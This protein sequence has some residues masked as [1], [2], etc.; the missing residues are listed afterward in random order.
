[1]SVNTWRS[2]PNIC[3]LVCAKLSWAKYMKAVYGYYTIQTTNKRPRKKGVG[4]WLSEKPKIWPHTTTILTSINKAH[5]KWNR[6]YI[7]QVL[8]TL[9][10]YCGTHNYIVCAEN[11]KSW[12]KS[13]VFPF[14][15]QAYIP[16][17]TLNCMYDSLLEFHIWILEQFCPDT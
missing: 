7:S 14:T 1:M 5:K 17:H 15:F 10:L 8:K 9:T 4:N 2:G 13:W 6:S 12:F 16:P 11:V 3:S